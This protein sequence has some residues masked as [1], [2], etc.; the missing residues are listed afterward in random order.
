M[1]IWEMT[2][3]FTLT[4]INNVNMKKCL[5][6]VMPRLI[7][8]TAIHSLQPWGNRIWCHIQDRESDRPSSRGF[9]GDL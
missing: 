9:C 6:S 7:L 2:R 1:G 3:S 4:G 5:L 8:Q